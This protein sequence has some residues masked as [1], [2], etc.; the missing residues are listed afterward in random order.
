MGGKAES[1]NATTSTTTSTLDSYNQTYSRVN[2]F[3]NVGNSTLTFNPDSG[4]NL[5][6]MLP[7]AIIG[8][9]LIGA[10]ALLRK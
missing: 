9:V 10:I 1:T 5:S 6:S 3:E 4:G 2:N 7:F 8:A